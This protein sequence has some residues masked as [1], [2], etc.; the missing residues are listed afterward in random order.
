[1]PI[2]LKMLAYS[3]ALCLLLAVPYTLGFIV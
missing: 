3:A 2:E 1:M